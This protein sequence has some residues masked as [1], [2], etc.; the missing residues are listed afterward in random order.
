MDVGA[1]AN[2]D[3]ARYGKPLDGIRV[4]AVEQMQSLPYATQLLARLGA[5]VVKIEHPGRGDLGR[6]ASPGVSDATGRHVGATFLRNNL[7]KRSVAIDL[8]Q[9]EGRD[10]V[11]A[12]APRFDVVAENS[13]PGS[14]EGFGLAYPDV[15][16]VHPGVVYLSV[17]GFGN[18]PGAPAGPYAGWPAFAPVAEA[19]AGL[20][21][22]A[23]PEGSPVQVSPVGALG[24]TGT[25]LFAVVGVLAALRHRDRTGEGQHVDVAMFDSMVAFGDIVPNYWSLGKDPR[26]PTAI[27]NH[28]FPIASGEIVVQVGREHQFERLVTVIGRPEW[29]TDQR[30][31]DR[32]GWLAHIDVLREAVASWAGE[33]TPVEAAGALADAGIAAAPVFEAADVVSDV[34]LAARNMLMAIPRHDGVEQPVLTPGNPV[35][36]SKMAEGPDTEPPPLGAHTAQVLSDE[37]GL[38]DGELERLRSAGVIGPRPD[39]GTIGS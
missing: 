10:L 5:D 9:P 20:Y 7:S 26:T 31:A 29:T 8:K 37:L 36:L 27:V 13:K 25:A 33:L 19:M 1:V 6:G 28:G 3:A 12:L 35:K 39:R 4:L 17:S 15:S 21:T 30:F 18:V 34:H 22:L 14:M 23:R 11:L 32:S 16:A 24:D 2:A 38:D